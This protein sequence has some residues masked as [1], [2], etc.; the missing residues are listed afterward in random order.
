MPCPLQFEKTGNNLQILTDYLKHHHP[1]ARL[2]PER[3]RSG[4]LNIFSFIEVYYFNSV[5]IFRA[6]GLIFSWLIKSEFASAN[7]LLKF[8]ISFLI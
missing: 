3:G 7:Q 5:F 4:I 1:Q 2:K 8:S 6:K